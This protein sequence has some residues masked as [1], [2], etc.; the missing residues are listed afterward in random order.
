MEM[1]RRH[2]VLSSFILE[3]FSMAEDILTVDI[4]IR[5]S[6]ADPNLP[7]QIPIE[8]FLA[9][10]HKAN[11]STV[12]NE[13]LA[14]FLNTVRLENLNAILKGKSFGFM[15]MAEAEEIGNQIIDKNIGEIL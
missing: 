6:K 4:P 11:Q 7:S 15:A 2:C 10:K 8:F 3:K 1:L 14:Q 13:N 5:F 12:N 9:K